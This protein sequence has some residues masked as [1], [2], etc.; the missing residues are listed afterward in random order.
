LIF[1]PQAEEDIDEIYDFTDENW[2]FE[3]AEA[4]RQKFYR[5]ADH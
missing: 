3:Q 2:G 4:T 1:S 5:S